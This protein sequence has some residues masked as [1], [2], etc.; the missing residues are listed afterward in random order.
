MD[1]FEGATEYIFV[2]ATR[3][4]LEDRIDTSIYPNVSRIN[5]PK[6]ETIVY[7]SMVFAE[8]QKSKFNLID[9]ETGSI[10]AKNL[11][12]KRLC[13]FLMNKCNVIVGSKKIIEQKT[14]KELLVNEF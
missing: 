8:N 3:G 10:V 7:I 6:L 11:D 2:Y 5:R 12:F 1:K 9:K 14:G 13:N 4:G